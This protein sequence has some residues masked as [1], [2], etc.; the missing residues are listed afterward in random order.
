M[1]IKNFV[2][3]V[4]CFGV[5]L[6][7]F[8]MLELGSKYWI[9]GVVAS[10][11]ISILLMMSD[12]DKFMIVSEHFSI[13]VHRIICLVFS[14]LICIGSISIEVYSLL[15]FS[16]VFLSMAAYPYDKQRIEA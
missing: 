5:F 16:V 6:S 3:A 8:V 4:F 2:S 10:V 1:R 13:R 7:G 9:H 12:P 14:F 15:G 11:A